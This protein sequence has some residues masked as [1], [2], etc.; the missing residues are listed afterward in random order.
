MTDKS[1]TDAELRRFNL[2]T[3]KLSS[4]TQLH[5]IEAR[6]EIRRFIEEHGKEKC[7]AMFEVLKRRDRKSA[8]R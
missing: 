2:I 6:M 4:R 5:R 1:Y 8:S 7:D 3:L